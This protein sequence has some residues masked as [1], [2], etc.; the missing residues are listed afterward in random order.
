MDPIRAGLLRAA[1]DLSLAMQ[2]AA[3]SF[4]FFSDGRDFVHLRHTESG[5]TGEF[6]DHSDEGWPALAFQLPDDAL[7]QRAS[8]AFLT[9]HAFF[10]STHSVADLSR[11]SREAGLP[12]KDHS[13]TGW[14]ARLGE[15]AVMKVTRPKSH[16][17]VPSPPS[18][19]LVS[20]RRTPEAIVEAIRSMA[21][22]QP[23]SS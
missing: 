10:S 15:Q 4:A 6:P 8:S 1:D 11:R 19:I 12:V 23:R 20:Q 14:S 22:R 9:R 16:F 5:L 3:R 18:L 17:G 2:N 7:F 13:K 21:G